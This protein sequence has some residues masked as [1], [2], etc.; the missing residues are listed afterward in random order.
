MEGFISARNQN[1]ARIFYCQLP[2]AEKN[3]KLCI[4]Y[5]WKIA[6]FSPFFLKKEQLLLAFKLVKWWQGKTCFLHFWRAVKMILPRVVMWSSPC[7][8]RG[9]EKMKSNWVG[10]K[11]K[12]ENGNYVRSN[13]GQRRID[14][15]GRPL[16]CSSNNCYNLHRTQKVGTE[17]FPKKA[18]KCVTESIPV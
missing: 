5:F 2:S 17:T 1:P 9:G 7:E 18:N 14:D 13:D 3:I 4:Y 12:I 11:M 10:M 6:F 15:S 16:C 8:L